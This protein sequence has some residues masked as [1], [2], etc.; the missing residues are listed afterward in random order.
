MNFVQDKRFLVR[1]CRAYRR[2][3]FGRGVLDRVSNPWCPLL[4]RRQV[5]RRLLLHRLHQPRQSRKVLAVS[6]YGSIHDIPT[7]R[8]AEPVRDGIRL[9]VTTS[10]WPI[11]AMLLR[12]A[13]SAQPRRPVHRPYGRGR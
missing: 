1:D 8:S 4:Q 10:P 7:T 2:G 3:D 9:P 13:A 5:R 11:V 6:P 12:R